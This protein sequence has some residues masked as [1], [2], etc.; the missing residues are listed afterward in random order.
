MAGIKFYLKVLHTCPNHLHK[1]IDLH[2]ELDIT[3]EDKLILRDLTNYELTIAEQLQL[4]YYKPTLNSSVF[5]NCS[6]YN[7][8][9]LGYSRTEE[10]NNKASLSYL[11]RNYSNITKLLHKKIIQAK[12]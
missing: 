5:A 1:F 2:P 6:V 11:N 7:K 12:F 9:A 4:D 8:G 3:R 10:M